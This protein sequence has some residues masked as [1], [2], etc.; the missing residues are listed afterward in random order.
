MFRNNFLGVLL[1]GVPSSSSDHHST[2]VAV[3]EA[4][5]T[6]VHRAVGLR[7]DSSHRGGV[8]AL[9][10]SSFKDLVV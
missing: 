5:I 8:D 6:R 4:F 1:V 7:E 9:A 3:R 10:A 2:H